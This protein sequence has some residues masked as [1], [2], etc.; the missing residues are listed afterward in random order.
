MVIHH[1]NHYGRVIKTRFFPNVA[2]FLSWPDVDDGEIIRKIT[3]AI[4]TGLHYISGEL[5]LFTFL[6]RQINPV[7]F[8]IFFG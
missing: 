5:R 6:H 2:A 4:A 3:K 8:R 7:S 1:G